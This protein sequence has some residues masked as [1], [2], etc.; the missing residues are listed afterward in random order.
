MPEKKPKPLGK[1]RKTLAST[2]GITSSGS[3]AGL[4]PFLGLLR[5]PLVPPGMAREILKEGKAPKKGG[6]RPQSWVPKGQACIVV[7]FSKLPPE[8]D[9][10]VHLWYTGRGSWSLDTTFV[11]FAKRHEEVMGHAPQLNP[12]GPGPEG[13]AE[14]GQTL[15]GHLAMMASVLQHPTR[16]PGKVTYRLWGHI[17]VPEEKLQALREAFSRA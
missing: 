14:G 9:M 15:T 2:G 12:D 6:E 8:P 1:E 11:E 3:E 16:D 4:I 13:L 17:L 5:G 10:P 7:G